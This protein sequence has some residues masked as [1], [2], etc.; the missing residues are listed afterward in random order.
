MTVSYS[1]LKKAAF[2]CLLL[3]SVIFVIGFLKW[4]IGVPVAILLAVAY[5]FAIKKAGGEEERSL[6]LS[7]SWLLLILGAVT[8]WCFFGGLGNLWAQSQDWSARN[9]IFRDLIRF[10]WPVVYQTKNAAL[11]YYIGYWLPAALCGKGVLALTGNIETAFFF[12]NLALLTW[13]VVCVLIVLLMVL[14]FVGAAKKWQIAVAVA[15]FILFSGVDLLGTLYN[16]VAKPQWFPYHIEWWTEYQFSSMTTALNW[17][18]NQ[19]IVAWMATICF[20]LEKRVCNYAFLIVLALSSSPLPAVG[21]GLYMVGQAVYWLWQAMREGKGAAFLR[22]V[23]S[24]QNVISVLTLLPIYFLYYKTN[25][26]VNVG[27]TA[28]EVP[29]RDWCGIAA[30]LALTVALLV[31][32][33]ILRRRNIP[34]PQKLFATLLGVLVFTV[35]VMLLRPDVPFRYFLF[36]F[37]N[38]TD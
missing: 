18:F 28:T 5:V 24:V 14:L 13:S 36:L 4:Y 12:G 38:S 26:A 2:F 21:L 19:S 10:E 30:L 33:L 15:V 34:F 17:V 23:I 16:C 6:T 35:A 9:A 22:D 3:P 20:L 37:F 11:V 7:L 32:A 1:T 31:T 27:H 29:T 25:L 8:L